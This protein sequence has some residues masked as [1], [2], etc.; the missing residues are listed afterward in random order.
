M[1]DLFTVMI[2]KHMSTRSVCG[3]NISPQLYLMPDKVLQSLSYCVYHT[4]CIMHLLTMKKSP[5]FVSYLACPDVC[6]WEREGDE[7]KERSD[8]AGWEDHSYIAQT[9]LPDLPPHSQ[10]TQPSTFSPSLPPALFHSLQ[11]SSFLA[12]TPPQFYPSPF[13]P[14][15]FHSPPSLLH[16]RPSSLLPSFP[17]L[18]HS[19]PSLTSD[20]LSSLPSSYLLVLLTSTSLCVSWPHIL[21]NANIDLAPFHRSSSF[22]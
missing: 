4:T 21:T 22:P 14:L 3:W 2:I 8:G 16:I 12:P 5:S 15:L 19:S 13:L 6:V 20:L 11:S 10:S 17:F 1:K 7:G 9:S 18:I